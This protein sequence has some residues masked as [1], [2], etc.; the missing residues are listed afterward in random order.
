ML[1][2]HLSFGLLL[3]PFPST[4]ATRILLVGLYSSSQI[5]CP[6]HLSWLTFTLYMSLYH[7]L[8]TVCIAHHCILFSIFICRSKD[9]SQSFSFKN[10]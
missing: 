1:S 4:T 6:A 7:S 5:T 2:S 10:S 8:Y 9:G 3:C